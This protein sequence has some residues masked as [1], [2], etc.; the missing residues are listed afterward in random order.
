[1]HQAGELPRELTPAERKLWSHLRSNQLGIDFRRQHAIG[2]YITDF[3]CIKKKLIIELDGGQHLEQEAYDNER[4][5]FLSSKGYRVLRFWNN[6]VLNDLDGV[7]HVIL[8][9]LE[10]VG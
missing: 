7:M 4:T 9:A 8:E 6:D 3:C 2:P 5:T 1:M 10:G